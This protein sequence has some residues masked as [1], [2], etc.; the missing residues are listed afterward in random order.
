WVVVAGAWRAS[1]LRPPAAP[2]STARNDRHS[3]LLQL[4]AW[5]VPAALA[6]AVLVTRDVDADELT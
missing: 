5:G 2:G 1:V 3:S 4:A 6:A